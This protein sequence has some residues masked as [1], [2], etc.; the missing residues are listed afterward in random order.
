MYVTKVGAEAELIGK[1]NFQIKII[2]EF[3]LKNKLNGLK[4]SHLVHNLISSHVN[5]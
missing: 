5:F 2:L 3:L 4:S 1:T